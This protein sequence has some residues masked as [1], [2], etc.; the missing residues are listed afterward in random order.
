ML[1]N[2]FLMILIVIALFLI[3]CNNG[4]DGAEGMTRSLGTMN[5]LVTS[6][7][8]ESPI[9]GAVLEIHSVPIETFP[10]EDV[11]GG[12][13]HLSIQ[14]GQDGRY[15][16]SVPV[17][18]IWIRADAPGFKRSPPQSWSLSP[19]STGELNF[20]LYPGEGDFPFDPPEGFDVVDE[21]DDQ[22]AFDPCFP[23]FNREGPHDDR[24]C[25][26]G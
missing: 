1:R 7:I 21:G 23:G 4:D 8:D 5:G 19:N 12:Q 25:G 14:C 26:E 10:P 16:V 3:G 22:E 13:I 20:I 15:I 18:R 9:T 11:V 2:Y 6:I 17:G 24:K